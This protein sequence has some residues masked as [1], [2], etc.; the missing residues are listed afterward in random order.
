VL[1]STVSRKNFT[2]VES[3]I[4]EPDSRA[5]CAA[6]EDNVKE[7]GLT[8]FGMTDKRQGLLQPSLA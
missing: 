5:Q 8:Y 3:F 2:T 4:E 1:G 6:L 7:F